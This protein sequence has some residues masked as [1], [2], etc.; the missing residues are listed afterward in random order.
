M[1]FFY[2][3]FGIQKMFLK[4]ILLINLL[5]NSNYGLT[6]TPS[7]FNQIISMIEKKKQKRFMKLKSDTSELFNCW[8]IGNIIRMYKW[9]C[10]ILD[11]KISATLLLQTHFVHR[12]SLNSLTKLRLDH[13]RI[14]WFEN[15]QK[16]VGFK[17]NVSNILFK[18]R[19]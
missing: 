13:Q 8:T 19:K 2:G 9:F 14:S 17:N 18:R 3:F 4:L 12:K 5:I 7:I 1:Q 15:V 6:K 16:K 10:H 11:V